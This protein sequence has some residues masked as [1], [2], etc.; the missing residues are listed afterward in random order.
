MSQTYHFKRKNADKF[1]LFGSLTGYAYNTAED[2]SGCGIAYLEAVNDEHLLSTCH[3][4]DLFYYIIDGEAEFN[5]AGKRFFAKATD[6]VLVPKNTEYGYKG[7]M[8]YVLFMSPAFTEGCE[9]LTD[10]SGF[11]DEPG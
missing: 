5:I 7:T 1:E 10:T 6:A 8:K 11:T 3:T 9:T 2:Y 4:S